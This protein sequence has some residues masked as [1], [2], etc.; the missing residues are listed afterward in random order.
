MGP[1]I[2]ALETYEEND[3]R[4]CLFHSLCCRRGQ[5]RQAHEPDA[6]GLRALRSFL[7]LVDGPGSGSDA[8]SIDGHAGRHGRHATH[9]MNDQNTLQSIEHTVM[10][11]HAGGRVSERACNLEQKTKEY[12]PTNLPLLSRTLWLILNLI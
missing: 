5:V 3:V 2:H 8:S 10:S 11:R 12:R 6:A 1:Y 9:V 7:A 4:Y